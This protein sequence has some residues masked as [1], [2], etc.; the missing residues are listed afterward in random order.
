MSNASRRQVVRG[1]NAEH[2][3]THRRAVGLRARLRKP[4]TTQFEVDVVD[5]STAGFR[6]ETGYILNPGATVWLTMPGLAAL[7]A[8][9]AW[10]DRYR[11][12]CA[13]RVPLHQAVL[14]HIVAHNWSGTATG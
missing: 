6:T 2:R 13:F 11:Y 10:R 1:S 12:G 8:V 14:D 7:E 9:V 3:R 5:L 4:G